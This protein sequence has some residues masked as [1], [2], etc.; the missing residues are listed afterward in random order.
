MDQKILLKNQIFFENTNIVGIKWITKEHPKTTHKLYKTITQ[1]ENDSKV[2]G[3][4]KT[5]D[6]SLC[7][8]IKQNKIFW[9]K[10]KQK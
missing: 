2:N 3:A 1:D 10:K 5:S 8:K 9:M 6:S 4:G 7:S